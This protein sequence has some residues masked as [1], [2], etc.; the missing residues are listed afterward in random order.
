MHVPGQRLLRALSNWGG[1]GVAVLDS[2][3]PFRAG[4]ARW[5]LGPIFWPAG[6]P[7]AA[8][9]G[10]AAGRCASPVRTAPGRPAGPS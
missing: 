6:G 1:G 9:T 8:Q 7:Q 2:Y 5:G 4:Q 3:T 10:D